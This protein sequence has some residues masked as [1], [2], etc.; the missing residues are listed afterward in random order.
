MVQNLARGRTSI[1]GQVS[2]GGGDGLGWRVGGNGKGT[3][4]GGG[5]LILEVRGAAI[6]AVKKAG[7]TG[8]ARTCPGPKRVS[9]AAEAA[10]EAWGEVGLGKSSRWDPRQ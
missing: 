6:Q 8:K 4:E 7:K 5:I 10:E 3:G 1:W 9:Q 2:G